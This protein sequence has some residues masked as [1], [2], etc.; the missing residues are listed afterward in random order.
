MTH[1]Q[2][3]SPPLAEL[4]DRD[5]Y[6]WT[7]ETAHLIEAQ[8]LDELDWENLLEEIESMGRAEKRAIKSNLKVLL[9][10]LLKWKYQP[11]KRSLSWERS[12]DEHRDRLLDRLQDSPSLRNYIPEILPDAYRRAVRDASKETRL[13]AET[14]PSACEWDLELILAEDYLPD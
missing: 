3:Q 14:F 7:Q 2:T 1:P 10:H 8:R 13:D 11:A 6:R 12:V 9:L 5:F 4:Y